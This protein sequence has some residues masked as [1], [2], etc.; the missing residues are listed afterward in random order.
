MYG[1]NIGTLRVYVKPESVDMQTILLEDT[2]TE[3]RN[4]YVVFEIKGQLNIFRL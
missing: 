1:V 3:A 4:D 2:E